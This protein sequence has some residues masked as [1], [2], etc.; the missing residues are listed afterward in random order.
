MQRMILTILGWLGAT[1]AISFAQAPAPFLPRTNH[2]IRNVGNGWN[3]TIVIDH[4]GPGSTIIQNSRNGIGNR[5]YLINDGRTIVLDGDSPEAS[6]GLW[7]HWASQAALSYAQAWIAWAQRLQA[8]APFAVPLPPTPAASA[9]F[10]GPL[11]PAPTIEQRLQ[12]IVELERLLDR[13][14]E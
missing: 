10:P 5:L 13:F 14:D 7:G 1:A 4:A 3:N 11:V 12:R 2:V 8:I 6:C 9:E